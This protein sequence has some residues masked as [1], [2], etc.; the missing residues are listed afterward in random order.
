LFSTQN[1][2]S[3]RFITINPPRRNPELNQKLQKTTE[4]RIVTERA[5]GSDSASGQPVPWIST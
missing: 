1:R 2:L 3:E 4:R 5:H